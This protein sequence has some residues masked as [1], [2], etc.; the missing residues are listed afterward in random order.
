MARPGLG[1]G[2]W[3]AV[4]R[5]RRVARRGSAWVGERGVDRRGQG[6]GC[7]PPWLGLGRGAGGSDPY[8]SAWVGEQVGTPMAVW[9]FSH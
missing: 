9:I 6:A 4:A 3:T 8:G 1:N 2:V 7:G 5:E